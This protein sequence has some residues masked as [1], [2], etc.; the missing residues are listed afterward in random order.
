MK[1]RAFPNTLL[2]DHENHEAGI[3]KLGFYAAAAMQGILG[4]KHGLTPKLVA[5]KAVD[6]A[7]ALINELEK[8]NSEAQSAEIYATALAQ[9]EEQES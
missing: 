9:N 4:T 3:S 8:R 1:A 5:K 6:Q 7:L 2:P